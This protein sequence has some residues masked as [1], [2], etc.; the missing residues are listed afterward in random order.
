MCPDLRCRVYQKNGAEFDPYDATW[1]PRNTLGEYSLFTR[2]NYPIVKWMPP[3]VHDTE[4][5]HS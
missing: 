5:C 3:S 2:D 4:A 1:V